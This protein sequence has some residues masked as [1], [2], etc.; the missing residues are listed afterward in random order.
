MYYLGL[1]LLLMTLVLSISGIE[2][3][4]FTTMHTEILWGFRA[5]FGLFFLLGL[6]FYTPLLS[7]KTCRVYLYSLRTVDLY[8][9]AG[10]LSDGLGG[11][12]LILFGSTLYA[13]ISQSFDGGYQIIVF[14]F[15]MGVGFL[16]LLGVLFPSKAY[17]FALAT[18]ILR[19]ITA[20][21]FFALYKAGTFGWISLAISMVDL[22]FVLLYLF[23]KD[24]HEKTTTH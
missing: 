1:E 9:I 18:V 7:L 23:L 19:L 11:M 21:G 14:G 13:L 16:H 6:L 22:L 4:G 5:V 3:A 15:V 20:A 8:N 12:M 17:T 10:F 2:Q 24:L